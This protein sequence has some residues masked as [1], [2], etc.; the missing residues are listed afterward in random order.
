MD[1][2]VVATISADPHLPTVRNLL[3]VSFLGAHLTSYNFLKGYKFCDSSN[4]E[5]GTGY[6]KKIHYYG[7]MAGT[8]RFYL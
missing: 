3:S 6:R 5:D 4:I 1:T 8:L 7:K 2:G